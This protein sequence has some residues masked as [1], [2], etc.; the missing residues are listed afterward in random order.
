MK[1]NGSHVACRVDETVSGDGV[2]YHSL[3]TSDQVA[4]ED[5]AGLVAVANVLEGL[6][7]ILTGNV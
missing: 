5:L 6:G 3:D 2:T 4:L 7:G 1:R